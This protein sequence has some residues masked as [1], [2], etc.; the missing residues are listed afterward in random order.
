MEIPNKVQWTKSL[1]IIN[2]YII[3][4]EIHFIY[5]HAMGL[6]SNEHEQATIK[7]K[8]DKYTCTLMSDTKCELWTSIYIKLTNTEIMH[9]EWP[10]SQSTDWLLGMQRNIENLYA[11]EKIIR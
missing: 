6:C 5:N 1:F 8:V 3:W 4:I 11:C 2:K 7:S 10:S 9:L